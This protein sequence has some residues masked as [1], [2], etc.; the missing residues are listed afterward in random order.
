MLIFFFRLM[1]SQK[2]HLK[3]T[4][5]NGFHSNTHV[6]AFNLKVFQP[7][8]Y[9][10][11]DSGKLL[12]VPVHLLFLIQS[13]TNFLFSIWKVEFAISILDPKSRTCSSGFTG[14][15]K[16]ELVVGKN[17]PHGQNTKRT[18][19]S[20]S[21][22]GPPTLTFNPSAIHSIC[23]SGRNHFFDALAKVRFVKASR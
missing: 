4:C 14:N 17:F 19:Q 7:I 21:K 5:S 16:L 20:K 9:L 15:C 23:T 10:W 2:N 3:T 8:K 1:W 22:T 6:V 13:R 12:Q 11:R 18:S